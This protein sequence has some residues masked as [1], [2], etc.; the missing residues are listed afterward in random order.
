[1]PGIELSIDEDGLDIHLLGYFVSRPEV[2]REAL[3][4]LRVDR[5]TRAAQIVARLLELGVPVEYDA[6]RARAL[7]GI[8][9]RPH[10]AE[11]MVARGHAVN[12]NDA[13]D[14]FL[15]SDRPAY[16]AKRALGLQEGV[17]LLRLA[18]AVP[19]VAH[20]GPSGLSGVLPHLAACGVLGLEVWHPKH[21]DHQMRR[22]GRLAEK[23]GFVPTG[24]S[25]FHREVPGGVLPGD[26]AIPREVLDALRRLAA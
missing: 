5:E 1:V 13:F 20:P 6:V 14:R 4:T 10:V 16:I 25:D 21:D 15:G 19:V 17:A 3:A 18:G 12:L 24:G 9:G 2:L 23:H 22:F 8:V 7:G 26:L 11:E